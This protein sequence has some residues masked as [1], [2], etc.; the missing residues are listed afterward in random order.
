MSYN[1]QN[2]NGQATK[3]NSSPV[4]L[5]SDQDALPI[6]DNSGSLTVD[7]GTATNLKTQAE[8]YQGGSAVGS[9]NPLQVTLANT[10]A[11][12]TAV[13]V[14]NSAVTQPVSG[15]ITASNA[16]GNIAHD[17]ADSGN[18][19]KQGAKATTSLHGLTLVADAD[20]TDLFAGID[21]VQ[22]VRPNANLESL[23]SGNASNTDGTSTQVIA[24]SGSG[25]KTYLT[26]VTLTNTSSSN[27]YVE[28]KDGSTA[29]WTFPVP[30]N[31]G[32][33]HHFASPIAGTAATAWNF[34]PSAATTTVYCS[35]SG[36]KSKI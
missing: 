7:Q 23:V 29:K 34:D 33:T 1:P 6:T 9:G 15:T 19:V 32:V 21:G 25:V 16:T 31:G 8:N 30:A 13:K 11:N 35:A 20:R 28:M 24:S 2:P 5:A 3:A 12:S 10:G 22:I 17:T 14:D 27:I 18:P 36:F 26:D 4:V